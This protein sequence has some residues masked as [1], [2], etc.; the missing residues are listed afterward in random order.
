M[1]RTRAMARAHDLRDELRAL[2]VDVSIELMPGRS[3]GWDG[4]RPFANLGHHVA[5]RR[6]QGLTP[7]LSLVKRGRSD[8]PG[9]LC[10][11]YGGFDMV[12][13]IIT[14]DWANHSGPGGSWRV[15]GAVIPRNNG[16]P[17]IFGWEMEGGYELSDWPADHREF[18]ARCFAATLKWMGR[19]ERSH[20][21]HGD[22]W[23]K[24]RK[25]DRIWYAQNLGAA[26]GE[27]RAILR[28]D[29]VTTDEEIMQ[30]SNE[31]RGDGSGAAV[32]EI[33]NDWLDGYNAFRAADGLP[34]SSWSKLAVDDIVGNDT[35]NRV[36][37]ICIMTRAS[38]IPEPGNNEAIHMAHVSLVGFEA[39]RLRQ[40]AN[41]LKDEQRGEGMQQVIDDLR[42]MMPE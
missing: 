41:S 33:C 29:T 26:R 19:D 42:A 31:K 3:G 5:S 10:N 14:M 30:R 28:G 8:L 37:S 1:S 18:M 27:I 2:N 38:T 25:F 34:A 22:P 11:G 21:E 35:I 4:M 17:Y 20:G 36:Q 13:R 12:A 24:G 32:Q 6:S 16:R 23:A 7:F 9:P 40:A 15:P 39:A